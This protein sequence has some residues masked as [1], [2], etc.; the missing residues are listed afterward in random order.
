[1]PDHAMVV[2]DRLIASAVTICMCT[3]RRPAAF[4]A[5]R[6]FEKLAGIPPNA[7]ELVVVDNDETDVLRAK[8]E[9]VAQ[10]YPYPLRYIHAPAQNISI[11]RNAAL[12]ATTTRWLAFIDDDETADPNWLSALL[13]YRDQAETVIGQCIA[14][15]GLDL[16]VWTARCDFHSNRIQGDATNAYTSNALLDMDFVRRHGLRFRVELGRTG[17]EDSIFFRQMKEAGGRIIYC[18]QAVVYEPV[19]Q[20]R[21]TMTWVRR[22]MYRAGQTH[23][24][25]CREFDPKAYRNLWLTAGAKMVVS[26]AMVLITVPGSTPSR[27]WFA[28]TMLHAGAAR[29]RLKPAMLEEYA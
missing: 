20:T 25:L 19:P 4:D 6:S 14:V 3:F 18:P 29:Y 21:A 15:Y 1:M 27:R 24:L 12:N 28:R 26:A 7:V 23:G 11:A 9:A 13:E 17:G 2:T 10:C 8:F 16:P 22:R 5:L